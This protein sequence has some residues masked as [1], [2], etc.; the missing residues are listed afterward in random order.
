MRDSNSTGLSPASP[1]LSRSR[2][3]GNLLFLLENLVMKDFRIRYRNMSLG[4]VWSIA[5]PLVMMVV[6][7]FVFTRIYPNP[8]VPHYAVFI[9][10]GLVPFNFYSL[11]FNS[12]TTSL[13]DNQSLVKRVRCPR[14]IF[15]I[16]AVLANCLH[17]LIQIGLLIAFVFAFGY[18]VNRFW[19]WLGVLWAMEILF[20]SGLA[21]ITSVLDVYYRD[22]RYLVEA[23]NVVMFWLVP[24]F[25]SLEMVPQGFRPLYLLNP[26]A[27]VVVAGREV[28]LHA[29]P[30]P[31]GVLAPLAIVSI[32][33]F[34]LGLT[35][36][37]RLERNIADN[38]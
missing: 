5:N 25:Y 31:P 34:A 22:V 18:R 32:G 19:P 36:F 12:G 20:M 37:G 27:A 16:A 30:P 14:R 29:K 28:L 10:C 11:A 4:V 17:F 1:N 26:I 7:T 13:L 21:L 3:G 9:L 38:L 33:C 15:P 2:G 23:S 35:V 8:S 24:I 6:L